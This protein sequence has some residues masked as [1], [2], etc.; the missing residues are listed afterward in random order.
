MAELSTNNIKTLTLHGILALHRLHGEHLT[1]S[2]SRIHYPIHIIDSHIANQILQLAPLAPQNIC[3]PSSEIKL[4]HVAEIP[5]SIIIS[6]EMSNIVLPGYL[7]NHRVCIVI[8]KICIKVLFSDWGYKILIVP[9]R[10][11]S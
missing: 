3:Q 8:F 11:F 7:Y 6:I 10:L 2:I 1:C 9:L 5:T 4:L